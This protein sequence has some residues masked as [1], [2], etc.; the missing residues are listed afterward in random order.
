MNTKLTLIKNNGLN[1][2][3]IRM[4]IFFS[5]IFYLTAYSQSASE[6]WESA[7]YA[8]THD[9]F[10][11]ALTCLSEIN[12]LEPKIEKNYKLVSEQYPGFYFL[13]GFSKFNL[14]DFTGCISDMNK[15]LEYNYHDSVN[16]FLFKARSKASLGDLYG[17]MTD[18]N[19]AM[20]ISPNS[21][22]LYHL[23]GAFKLELGDKTGACLDWSRSGELGYIEAYEWIKMFCK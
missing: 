13:R 21:G 17:A 22:P 6:Y 14:K 19:L 8:A 11:F 20:N 1:L 15:C 18:I 5:I 23:R 3:N 16:I 4:T 12:R 2:I 9:D 7:K 10:E